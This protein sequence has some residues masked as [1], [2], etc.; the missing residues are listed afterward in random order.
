M[1]TSKILPLELQKDES[2]PYDIEIKEL[3]NKS[4]APEA[5]DDSFSKV[6]PNTDKFKEILDQRHRQRQSLFRFVVVLTTSSFG[7]LV[8]IVAVQIFMR[9]RVDR[10]FTVFTGTEFDI[11]SVAI[12]GQIIGV[13]Y[14]ITKALWDDKPYLEKMLGEK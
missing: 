2:E 3:L 11:L 8:V 6:E 4:D 9:T 12:F 5:S 10:N 7:M 13:V 14:I 1:A